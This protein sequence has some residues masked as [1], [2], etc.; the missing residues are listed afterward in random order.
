MTEIEV[1]RA[2]APLRRSHPWLVPAMVGLGLSAA[3][4]EGVSLSLFMPFLYS[5]GASTFAPPDVGWLSNTLQRLF[6]SFPASERLVAVAVGMMGLVFLKNLLVYAV[7]V[8]K[9]W[10][11]TILV[12]SLRARLASHLLNVPIDVV[13]STDSGKLLNALQNQTQET[14]TAF[15]AYGDLL[16]HV[17]TSAFFAILLLLVSWKLTLG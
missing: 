13:E 17:C 9:S 4:S 6:E 10:I 2:L 15:C 14:G 5:L 16:V 3:L 1:V 12:H 8:L 7:E 11:R